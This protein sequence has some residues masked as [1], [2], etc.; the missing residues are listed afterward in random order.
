MST[1]EDKREQINYI[2]V[3][4][5]PKRFAGSVSHWQGPKMLICFT[6]LAAG[7]L[8]SVNTDLAAQLF[9]NHDYV[10]SPHEGHHAIAVRIFLISFFISFAAFSS[11]AGRGRVLFGLD[12]VLTFLVGCAAFDV[13]N[14]VAENMIG[15]SLSLHFSAIASGLFGFAIYSFKLL[16]RGFMPARIRVE[17][18]PVSQMRAFLRL[19]ISIVT[20]AIIAIWVGGMDLNLVLLLR[21]WTLLGGIG[22]GVFLFLPVLFGQLYLLAVYDVLMAQNLSSI[23]PSQ[24]SS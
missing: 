8:W 6:G 9:P 11:A 21:H 4:S 12:M 5:A 24:S 23:R 16:E 20:A 22:P 1:G 17:H 10:F 7:Q 14:A 13:A 3:D 15:R 18:V 2:S 19:G